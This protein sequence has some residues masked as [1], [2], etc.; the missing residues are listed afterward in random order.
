MMGPSGIQEGA[1]SLWRRGSSGL[2]KG[3]SEFDNV[4]YGDFACG[5]DGR[6]DE[7][8]VSPCGAS[9]F[10]SDQKE[11]KESLG[12]GLRVKTLRLSL[13]FSSPIPQTP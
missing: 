6:W 12:E 10:L 7:G 3:K 13:V 1:H 8:N 5:R 9:F 2:W 4:I 11:T